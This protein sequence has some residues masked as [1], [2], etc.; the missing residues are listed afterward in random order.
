[1]K[2][3]IFGLLGL[4][5][6]ISCFGKTTYD[7]NCLEIESI[8]GVLVVRFVKNEVEAAVKN[9]ALKKEGKSY[10]RMVD[11]E[12]VV[13]FLPTIDDNVNLTKMLTSWSPFEKKNAY[14]LPINTRN[15]KYL[16]KFYPEKSEL[17]ELVELPKKD[18]CKFYK[19][20]DDEK[21]LYRI[22]HIEGK[23]FT[24]ELENNELN[25]IKL[26]LSDEIDKNEKTFIA[27]FIYKLTNIQCDKEL[28]NFVVWE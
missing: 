18:S 19:L 22:Y 3:T 1:M 20:L 11:Y 21:Y 8:R 27:H 16:A 28:S 25:K 14:Y 2:A 24:V 9:E 26:D 12:K 23:E 13:F 5:L 7:E 10:D 17:M 4:V 6:F 15:K